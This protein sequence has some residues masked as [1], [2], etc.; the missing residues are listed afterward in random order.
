M[1]LIIHNLPK[2][3][4][5]H[6]VKQLIQDECGL[7]EAILDNL[8]NEGNRKRITVGLAEEADAALLMTKLNGKLYKNRV[9]YV[10]DV[11]QKKYSNQS[12]QTTIPSG[13][14]PPSLTTIPSGLQPTVMKAQIQ[15]PLQTQATNMMG[16]N[17]SNMPYYMTQVTNPIM[18]HDQLQDKQSSSNQQTFQNTQSAYQALNPWGYPM[19]VICANKIQDPTSVNVPQTY[20]SYQNDRDSTNN[21]RPDNQMNYRENESPPSKRH[22][23]FGNYDQGKSRSDGKM[24]SEWENRRSRR[25]L[26]DSRQPSQGRARDRSW[27]R[28]DTEPR[29]SRSRRSKRDR[30]SYHERQRDSERNT[31]DRSDRK[32]GSEY[33]RNERYNP[34]PDQNIYVWSK[35]P[36]V[37]TRTFSSNP[38]NSTFSKS[39]SNVFGT[40][41]N[42]GFVGQPSSNRMT[43]NQAKSMPP[44][45]PA[46]IVPPAKRPRFEQNI[47][48]FAQAN[49]NPNQDA[50][51]T[52]IDPQK[53]IMRAANWRSQAATLLAK[54][55]IKNGSTTKI[56]NYVFKILLK[57]L[58][59]CVTL[60]LDVI[61]GDKIISSLNEVLVSY[62]MKFNECNDIPFFKAIMEKVEREIGENAVGSVPKNDEIQIHP[63]DPKFRSAN[64]PTQSIYGNSNIQGA[65][66]NVLPNQSQVQTDKVIAKVQNNQKLPKY[67]NAELKKNEMLEYQE[68]FYKMEPKLQEAVDNEIEQLVQCYLNAC[69]PSNDPDEEI[70][71]NIILRNT[72]DEFKKVIKLQ[73]TKRVLNITTGLC[74]RIFPSLKLPSRDVLEAFL[75]RHGVVS[76]KKSENSSKMLIAYCDSY[77]NYDRMLALQTATFGDNIGIQIKPLHLIGP[78]VKKS[79]NENTVPNEN[80][81]GDSSKDVEEVDLTATDLDKSLE[82]KD[83]SDV[84]FIENQNDVVLIHD[85]S[86]NLE[87]TTDQNEIVVQDLTPKDSI[88]SDK[89]DM[90][91]ETI[92]V[93]ENI[94]NSVSTPANDVGNL[95]ENINLTTNNSNTD[96]ETTQTK[97]SLPISD[98]NEDGNI[99]IQ[100]TTISVN[101]NLENDI[102]NTITDSECQDKRNENDST[103]DNIENSEKST[104]DDITQEICEE[105]VT[106]NTTQQSDGNLSEENSINDLIIDESNE[107]TETIDTSKNLSDSDVIENNQVEETS[108]EINEE[109]IDDLLNSVNE[110]D[111][112]D[113]EDF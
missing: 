57:K 84:M 58:R 69:D 113:L 90:S 110:I 71:R 27:D 44:R 42:F 94:N 95:Q 41:A 67:P 32:R 108:N 75:Q 6:D 24:N 86:F 97:D 1:L 62:R 63:R 107:N 13:L 93:N 47:N 105:N 45:Q 50:A 68:D 73:V 4:A 8:L 16:L 66:K 3:A 81:K 111:E 92:E 96:E 28:R 52:N 60:R 89:N 26:S 82:D 2:D 36:N 55:V 18:N 91:K 106:E 9:L 21:A 7:S 101:D 102:D 14:Q 31:H 74:V 17:Y 87:N 33:D 85:E 34:Q 59:E 30:D 23:S 29:S 12:Y 80:E 103:T 65:N 70:V 37:A 100:D 104:T 109:Q 88:I 54:Q 5:Y 99:K 79:K 11:R 53:M 112:D 38:E 10:E 61:L 51:T 46:T 56:D 20:E 25:D 35:K 64:A 22:E 40:T 77:E 48:S 72:V 98:V 83:D 39:N 19:N 15:Y 78:P 76:L 49:K 43:F